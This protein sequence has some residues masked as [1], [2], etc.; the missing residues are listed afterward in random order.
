MP[1]CLRGKHPIPRIVA[2]VADAHRI[3]KRSGFTACPTL[4]SGHRMNAYDLAEL[5]RRLEPQS[6]TVELKPA[7]YTRDPVFRHAINPGTMVCELRGPRGRGMVYRTPDGLFYGNWPC[8]DNVGMAG[9]TGSMD[10]CL[11]AVM[12]V[13]S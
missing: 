6:I 11:K 12:L 3:G 4:E 8:A 7:D 10:Q 1:P 2:V 13:I 9:T 5:R